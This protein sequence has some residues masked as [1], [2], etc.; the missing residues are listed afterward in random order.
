[1]NKS[2]KFKVIP[3]VLLALALL[4]AACGGTP[5]QPGGDDPGSDENGGQEQATEVPT[6][7]AHLCAHPYY[8]GASLGATWTYSVTGD[9]VES[10]TFT[11]TV[12]DV[13]A[14]GFTL[15]S[16]FDEL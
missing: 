5:E 2:P 13:R 11:D 15:T 4:L 9:Q 12:T 16:T 7:A 1:M 6:E 3:S 14:D 8:P 10:F